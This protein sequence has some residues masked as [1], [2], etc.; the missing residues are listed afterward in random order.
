M[1]ISN[2]VPTITFNPADLPA[3]VAAL[4]S[5]F[6]AWGITPCL[7][8]AIA[9]RTGGVFRPKNWQAFLHRASAE[10]QEAIACEARMLTLGTYAPR[11]KKN[12]GKG[13]IYALRP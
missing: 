3:P 6:E 1:A 8:E 12:L 11:I 2:T 4:F 5:E 9:R 7:F 13:N 10:E